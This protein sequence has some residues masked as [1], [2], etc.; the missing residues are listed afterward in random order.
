MPW[1]Q[2]GQ[3]EQHEI[4]PDP[5]DVSYAQQIGVREERRRAPAQES[6]APLIKRNMLDCDFAERNTGRR[7]FNGFIRVPEAVCGRPS[8]GWR[9]LHEGETGE[10]M[11]IDSEGERAAARE[12]ATATTTEEEGRKEGAQA[13]GREPRS[14]KNSSPAH[15]LQVSTASLR[16]QVTP[17]TQA[18]TFLIFH[19]SS[20]VRPTG[21]DS[22]LKQGD[23]KDMQEKTLQLSDGDL[24]GRGEELIGG[25]KHGREAME[26]HTQPQQQLRLQQEPPASTSP[27]PWTL[28]CPG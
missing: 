25:E 4:Y 24:V 17:I 28:H 20:P 19:T 21:I 18:G 7:V 11:Q 5:A 1:Q 12:H 22:C 27:A 2:Q 8:S 6:N 13:Q 9:R 3:Q 15:P 14:S 23:E 16:H 10:A 26:E